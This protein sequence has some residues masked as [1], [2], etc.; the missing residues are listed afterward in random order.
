MVLST[1]VSLLEVFLLYILLYMV[2]LGN[3]VDSLNSILMNI[4]S[5]V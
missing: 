4:V 2:K 5:F 3:V 1:R